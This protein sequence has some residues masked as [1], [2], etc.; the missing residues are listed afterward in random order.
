VPVLV[1][2]VVVDELPPPPPQ[3]SSVAVAPNKARARR[4]EMISEQ[5]ASL[6]TMAPVAT[7]GKVQGR[8]VMDFAVDVAISIRLLRPPG[9]QQLVTTGVYSRRA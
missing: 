7:S 1:E 8:Y 9:A 6:F 5:G 2:E 4:C 3:P